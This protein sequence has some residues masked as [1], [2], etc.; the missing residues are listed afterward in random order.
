MSEIAANIEAVRFTSVRSR[1]KAIFVGSIGNLVEWYDF[2][3]YTA[4][5]LYFAG[6]FFPGKNPVVQQLNA[7]LLFAIG[8]IMRPIGGWL[9]GQNP[10]F[11]PIRSRYSASPTAGSP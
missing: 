11:R 9:F 7:A 10:T 2:Y 5:A 1:L 4:F 6:S 8:F 3:A